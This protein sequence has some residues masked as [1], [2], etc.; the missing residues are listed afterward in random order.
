MKKFREL[1]NN[2]FIRYAVTGVAMAIFTVA[3][4][5]LN[6][7]LRLNWPQYF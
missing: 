1:L 3:Y 7:W 4:M 5:F 2:R 6:Y